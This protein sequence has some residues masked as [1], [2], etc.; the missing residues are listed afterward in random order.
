MTTNYHYKNLQSPTKI[1]LTEAQTAGHADH[2]RIL[3]DDMSH[4]VPEWLQQMIEQATM[5]KGLNSN[6]SAKDSC[7]LLSEDQPCHINQV[8]AMKDG[9][10]ERFVNAYPCVDSL[11][12]LN[13]TIER[14]IVNETTHD[15]VLRLRTADGSIIYAFDQLY[16]AN[17][18]L[19]QQ[20][21]S[22]FVNFSAWAHE[23]TISEQQEVIMV[24][25]QE[26]IRS[27]RAFN[28]IVAANN[29][30]VPTDIQEQ[31]KD[32][33]PTTKEQMEPVEINLGHMCAYL[34]G[35]TLGQE[36][37]AWCQGQVLGK[38]QCKFNGKDIILFDVVILR[39]QDADPFVVRIAAPSTPQTQAIGVLN[40]IQANIWLQAAIYKE[41]QNK[42][43]T[44][45]QLQTQS[46]AS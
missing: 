14:M 31:V 42:Q 15:A 13:C 9:K 39:E 25:D 46:R 34:F 7:L 41:N 24:E 10:P 44:K 19:Y 27:H 21:T 2:W 30:Q 36:D 12:G 35:D 20:G 18:H 3:T 11:Y 32:W 37:E 29:G 5:P 45:L 26:A 4:D 33:Q 6:V 38:Q 40:Y 1:T 22:Y 8:L 23:I 16:T 43:N 28:D 17:R